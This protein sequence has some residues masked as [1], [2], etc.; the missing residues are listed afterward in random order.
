ME[1]ILA[2]RPVKPLD[3]ARIERLR[4]FELLRAAVVH[5]SGH[6]FGCKTPLRVVLIVY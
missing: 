1:I 5:N 4:R 3:I 2:M 6:R